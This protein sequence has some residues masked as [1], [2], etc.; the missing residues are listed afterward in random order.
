MCTSS[1]GLPKQKKLPFPWNQ[2]GAKKKEREKKKIAFRRAVKHRSRSYSNH[3][4]CQYRFDFIQLFI[5]ESKVFQGFDVIIDLADF[6]C[7]NQH[8]CDFSIT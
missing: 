5:A 8:A 3:L 1:G 4:I 2:R 7:A 6:A